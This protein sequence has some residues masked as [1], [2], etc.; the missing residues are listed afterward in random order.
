ML[1]RPVSEC[2]AHTLEVHRAI[3]APDAP[4]G[5][6]PAYVRREHDT[7]VDAVVRAAAG[8]QSRL[9]VLV[10]GSSTGKTRCC[11]EAVRH[12]LPGGWR[13]F[14][15]ISRA[16]LDAL[17]RA[18]DSVGERTVIWLNDLQ[19]YV[20]DTGAGTGLVAGLRELL[21]APERAPVL[22]IGTL[23]PQHWNDLTAD[24]KPGGPDPLKQVRELLKSDTMVPVPD[25]FT[26]ADLT[27]AGGLA[28]NDPRLRKAL[29][30][31]EDGQV[32]QF[33]AGAPALLERYRIAP[34][35]ARAL[36]DAAVGARRLGH[37]PA[38]PL[39]LLAAAVPG[40]L[41]D[42]DARELAHE[43]GWLDQALA[44]VT[45]RP[46]DAGG[47]L[48]RAE[49]DGAEP[50]Y[51]LAD[52]LEQTLPA[53]PIPVTL[54]DALVAHAELT[55]ITALGERTERRGYYRYAVDLYRAAE[56]RGEPDAPLPL[57][58]LLEKM[59]RHDEALA[60][61]R[62]AAMAAPSVG[63]FETLGSRLEQ[64]GQLREALA[65]YQR[66]TEL[67]GRPTYAAVRTVTLLQQTRGEQAAI[68]WLE[69][70]V[71]KSRAKTWEREWIDLLMRT[72]EKAG[73]ID[74]AIASATRLV[75]L[76][77]S[78]ER[79]PRPRF[80]PLAAAPRRGARLALQRLTGRDWSPRK[81][82]PASAGRRPRRRD[83]YE[84]R[85]SLERLMEL[86]ERA[87]RI[88]DAVAA[89]KRMAE[90]DPSSFRT[91]WRLLERNGRLSSEVEWLRNL[92]DAR[93]W[94]AEIRN[95]AEN[96][97]AREEGP[98][99]ALAWARACAFRS[100]SQSD[101]AALF[102]RTEGADA[103]VAWLRRQP[104]PDPFVLSTLLEK[105]GQLADALEVLQRSA[106]T[107]DAFAAAQAAAL[108]ERANRGAE[109]VSWLESC[110]AGEVS[111]SLQRAAIRRQLADLLE[112]CGRAD[113][114]LAVRKRLLNED[115][116]ATDV[117]RVVRA[118][119]ERGEIE[120]ALALP[121][122]TNI[123]YLVRDAY[124]QAISTLLELGRTAEAVDLARRAGDAGVSIAAFQLRDLYQ[125][126]RR[127][128][129]GVI[130]VLLALAESGGMH[131]LEEAAR[132][133]RARGR[134]A[135]AE[136]LERFGIEPGGAIADGPATA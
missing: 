90:L 67:A 42:R 2:S 35:R 19:N 108:L 94:S 29:Q 50:H 33:L 126:E 89:A 87:G 9:V 3:D 64:A 69:S 37:E 36:I 120:E 66:C 13:L 79:E 46:H 119:V 99:P 28:D 98:G 96:L 20:L 41:R 101:L 132:L 48:D 128:A 84:Q 97:I 10:G 45:Y 111:P 71:K 59:G 40:Y 115:H 104:R 43:P 16:H 24:P 22:V 34:P 80:D 134:D 27:R 133:L 122:A 112:R 54:L 117:G 25:A 113:E 53:G 121:G 51:R 72:Y 88:D 63:A 7:R 12:G 109:A 77:A 1:G 123:G 129:D 31:A 52:Y 11:W 26:D 124:A 5:E 107:G 58:R 6:L 15:P 103:A 18:R 60:A 8:G 116:Y 93:P 57:A 78:A 105:A 55:S 110:A 17:A 118:L 83:P 47:A 127:N 136:R 106:R 114:A 32:T 39:A 44:Y 68:D 23:W 75:E 56:K 76:A 30:F 61:S 14:H 82:R 49:A 131:T 4:P 74:D 125:I 85:R 81:R 92:A 70:R 65:A 102:Q 38:L 21:D 135:E 100:G 130:A 73:R 62:R 95:L 86:Y 91:A